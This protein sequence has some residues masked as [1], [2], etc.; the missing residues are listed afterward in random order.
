MC[1]KIGFSRLRL[2]DFL[3]WCGVRWRRVWGCI[4]GFRVCRV[5]GVR[6]FRYVFF[7]FING[8][9]ISFGCFFGGC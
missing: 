8:F 1:G 7:G 4:N 3:V 6:V 5:K 2:G 9:I